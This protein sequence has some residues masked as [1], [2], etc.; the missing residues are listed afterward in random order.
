MRGRV[1][2]SATVSFLSVH[3]LDCPT[4]LCGLPP[5]R[6][7]SVINTVEVLH[8]AMSTFVKQVT[9]PRRYRQAAFRACCAIGGDRSAQVIFAVH[10]IDPVIV[11]VKGNAAPSHDDREDNEQKTY[12]CGTGHEPN[13]GRLDLPPFYVPVVMRVGSSGSIGCWAAGRT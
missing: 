10:A 6:C 3:V 7:G 9:P 1:G 4:F 2:T 12:N 5:S 11:S 8:S 13:S